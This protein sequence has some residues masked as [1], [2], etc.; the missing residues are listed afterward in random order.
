MHSGPVTAGVVGS[1]RTFFRL[2]GDTVNVS[3]RMGSTGQTGRIHISRQ[4]Y[5]RLGRPPVLNSTVGR[6]RAA[7]AE[8]SDGEDGPGGDGAVSDSSEEE[9]MRQRSR[10]ALGKGGGSRVSPYSSSGARSASTGQRFFDDE[11]EEDVPPEARG[12]SSFVFL[13]GDLEDEMEVEVGRED[14]GGSG[15]SAT[16][17]SAASST[18]SAVD[19]KRR[20]NRLRLVPAQTHPV[21]AAHRLKTFRLWRHLRDRKKAEK[22]RVKGIKKRAQ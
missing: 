18:S 20:R 10:G 2:V 11:D 17:T 9:V 19:A 3:S 6:A 12:D 8:M 7:L 13:S 4:A 21:V 16:S 22:D 14:T 15:G 5:R 1:Q